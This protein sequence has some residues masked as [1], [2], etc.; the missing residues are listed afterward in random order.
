MTGNGPVPLGVY[1]RDDIWPTAPGIMRSTDVTPG[2]R[3]VGLRDCPFFFSSE[4]TASVGVGWSR[5][6]SGE[7]DS[8][9]DPPNDA[10]SSSTLCIAA[11][12]LPAVPGERIESRN[13]ESLVD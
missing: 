1:T 12:A 2:M 10:S 8:M 7:R 9:G 6:C 5:A 11:V 13:D 4:L 3:S